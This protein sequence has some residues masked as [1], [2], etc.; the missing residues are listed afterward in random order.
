MTSTDMRTAAIRPTATGTAVRAVAA[1]LGLFTIVFGVWAFGWPNE[2]ADTVNFAP[3]RHFVH[4]VGAFQLG[5]GAGLLLATVWAD[6]L[7]VTLAAYAVAGI[8]HTISHAVDIGLGGGDA[9]TI[10]VGLLTVLSIVALVVRWRQ[11]GWIVGET[12]PATDPAL[13]PFRDQKTVRLVTYK[14]DGTPVATAVSIAVEGDHAYV[15]SFEKA[16]KTRR[17][18]NNPAVTVAPST[19]SGTPTGPAVPA[20]ARRLTGDEYAHAARTL[21]R[22]HPFLHG[23]FV[24]LTHRLARART[25]RTVHFELVPRD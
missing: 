2:F 12:I 11:R 18:R 25:G 6:A 9:Q 24:P 8:A 21:A 14:R 20:T 4:D 15:R 1:L 19:F 5:I 22:K 16:W 7:L 10:A 23:C 3:N 13:A 17:I